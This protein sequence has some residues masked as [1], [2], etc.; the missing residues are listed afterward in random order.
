MIKTKKK[1]SIRE[2]AKAVAK[3]P[4]TTRKV[5][6]GYGREFNSGYVCSI[7]LHRSSHEQLKKLTPKSATFEKW[8]LHAISVLQSNGLLSQVTDYELY[9]KMKIE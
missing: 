6:N 5:I 1:Y 4:K 9:A 8:I 2:E 7:I 3:K